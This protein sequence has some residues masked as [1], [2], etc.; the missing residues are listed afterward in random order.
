MTGALSKEGHQQENISRL[1][2]MIVIVGFKC[3]SPMLTSLLFTINDNNL[4][5]IYVCCLF[6]KN[7]I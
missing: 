2:A 1:T 5:I 3:C 4:I 7:L 6:I